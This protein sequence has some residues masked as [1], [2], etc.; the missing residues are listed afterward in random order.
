[1]NGCRLTFLGTGT[2]QGIP[3]VGCDCMVCNSP[4]P[5]DRRLRASAFV[6]YGGKNILVDCGPDFRTQMLRA[7]I[8]KLDAILLTHAHMD[9]I[10]GL[11]DTRALQW[12]RGWE[13]HIWCEQRVL[14]ALKKHFYYAFSDQ[15]Y[16]GVATWHF[17]IID[18]KPFS[19]DGVEIVPIRVMHGKLPILGFRFGNTAYITDMSSIESS[20]EEKL[21]GLDAITV[22]CVLQVPHHSHFSL[23]QA[24]EFAQRIGARESYLTHLSHYLPEHKKMERLLPPHIHPAYDGL[25][26]NCGRPEKRCPCNWKRF[27][28]R[29]RAYLRR[30]DAPALTWHEPEP[31]H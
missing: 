29:T 17:H 21:K 4:D 20:E 12:G 8:K 22:N 23:P 7:G 2:S 9:H 30:N 10:G 1:M 24:V 18:D 15:L 26:I 3:V 6:E 13:P 11:D 28:D 16:P 19:I 27:L 25:T 5:H 31:G 14:D